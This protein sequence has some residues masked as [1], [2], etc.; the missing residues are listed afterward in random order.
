M[1]KKSVMFRMQGR[2]IFHQ[3]SVKQESGFIAVKLKNEN[4]T[5]KK[6]L[7]EKEKKNMTKTEKRRVHEG[8]CSRLN[9]FK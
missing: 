6:Q 9:I 3:K 1:G 2:M 4:K 8:F 5:R 7:E